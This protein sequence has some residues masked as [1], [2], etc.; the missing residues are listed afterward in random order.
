[1]QEVGMRRLIGLILF[2]VGVGMALVLIFPKS[3]LLVCIA[4]GLII[5]GYN[6]FCSC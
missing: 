3:F 5:A 2:W 6:L 1:M 4:A